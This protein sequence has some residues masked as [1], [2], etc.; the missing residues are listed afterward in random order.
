MLSATATT[1]QFTKE[2][3][4]INAKDVNL[5]PK[6]KVDLNAG[7]FSNIFTERNPF[8]KT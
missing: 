3:T 1:Y 7:Y 8:L 2:I 6:S 5:M 4:T